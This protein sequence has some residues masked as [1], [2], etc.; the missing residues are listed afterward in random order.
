MRL[1]CLAPLKY[2]EQCPILFMN[3]TCVFVFVWSKVQRSRDSKIEHVRYIINF[4]HFF[5]LLP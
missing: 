3:K 5:A 1:F 2:L 4:Y